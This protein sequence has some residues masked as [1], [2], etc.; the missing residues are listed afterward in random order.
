MSV[1]DEV[2]LISGAARGMGANEARSF[3]AAGAKLVLGDVLED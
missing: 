1:S 2:V 3:A